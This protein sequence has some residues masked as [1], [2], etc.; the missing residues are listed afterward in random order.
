[1]FVYQILI[2]YDGSN[3]AGWQIQQN[4][5]TV[6]EEIQQVIKKILKKKII[7]Y[8]SGRTDKGVHA[9]EQS[10]H[11][12]IDFNIINT[13]KFLKS[14]NFFLNKKNI[15]ILNLKKKTSSFHARHSAKKRVYKYVII[16]RFSPL[17]LERNRAWYIKKKLDI[18]LIKKGGKILKG[19]K[20][21]STYRS[22]SC[23]AKSP[24]KT[25]ENVKIK[26]KKDKIE[27]TFK[28][29]SFLQQQVRSMVGCL[30]YLGEKKWTLK[31]F[32]KVMIAKKR[33]DCAPPAPPSGLYLMKI[34]Y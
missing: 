5:K 20:D 27:I 6:Q 29:K 9:I 21:F 10:A 34:K 4:V 18:N 13:E 28:S 19:T 30:K 1:M 7:L 15:S 22:S 3:F 23:N 24:I 8:G 14:L 12:K 16:N 31:K 33:V 2:E 11:F 17:I 26:K 32:K 25:L